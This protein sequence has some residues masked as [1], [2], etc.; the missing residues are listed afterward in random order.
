MARYGLSSIWNQFTLVALSTHRGLVRRRRIRIS[1]RLTS[2]TLSATY[3]TSKQHFHVADIQRITKE[4]SLRLVQ[5]AGDILIMG[6]DENPPRADELVR[7]RRK[8]HPLRQALFRALREMKTASAKANATRHS[9]ASSSAIRSQLRPSMPLTLQ[10][11][12]TPRGYIL[13]TGLRSGRPWESLVLHPM[14]KNKSLNKQTT[15]V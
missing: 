12:T 8:S 15:Q 1:L 2:P 4:T 13:R 5:R 3:F 7:R 11:S 10:V 6:R 14:G 9:R